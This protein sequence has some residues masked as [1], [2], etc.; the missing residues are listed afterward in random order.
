MGNKRLYKVVN[1][2]EENEKT[3]DFGFLSDEDIKRA[4]RGYKFNSEY[5]VFTRKGVKTG[6]Y[7]M[8][9]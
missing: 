9:E 5:Q 7:L 2:G 4:T 8:G 3:Y 6:F 1:I